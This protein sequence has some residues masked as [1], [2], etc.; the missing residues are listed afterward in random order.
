MQEDERKKPFSPSTILSKSVATI[1]TV[2][3]NKK[4][5]LTT[6]SN[7]YLECKVDNVVAN[8]VFGHDCGAQLS[9]TITGSLCA[10]QVLALRVPENLQFKYAG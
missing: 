1:T 10:E 2:A 7:N 6:I 9:L 8:V 4:Q 5:L 3:T